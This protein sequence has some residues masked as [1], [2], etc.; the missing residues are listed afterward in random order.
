MTARCNTAE[1]RMWQRAVNENSGQAAQHMRNKQ[2]AMCNETVG[3]A[4]NT[5]V[6]EP[7]CHVRLTSSSEHRRAKKCKRGIAVH[8]L[9]R[10]LP[11]KLKA[12]H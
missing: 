3:P 11:V 10:A 9:L 1:W 5:C 4:Q 6:S 7:L 12:R 8:A 2:Q